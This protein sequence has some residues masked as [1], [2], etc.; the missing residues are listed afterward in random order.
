MALLWSGGKRG[1][2]NSRPDADT[3][4]PK[5]ER[6]AQLIG[7]ERAGRNRLLAFDETGSD[8]I[9]RVEMNESPPHSALLFVR[10]GFIRFGF[11][12]F[13]L[14]RFG[15]FRRGMLWLG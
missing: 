12:R 2:V 14:F 6:S 13:G 11:I 8:L 9:C 4:L 1:V 5:I 3:V 10:F 15:L 7:S